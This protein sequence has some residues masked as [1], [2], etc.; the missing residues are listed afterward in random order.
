MSISF[1]FFSS[2]RRHTR[3]KCDWSS[4]VCS[5]DLWGCSRSQGYGCSPFKEV[6]EL[7]LKRRE[8]VWSLSAVGAGYLK[9][10]APSTRGPEWTNLWCTGLHASGIAGK[11]C[12]EDITPE[13]PYATHHPY[14]EIS[15]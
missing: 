7:G 10:A 3:F 14:A 13:P 2:R 6:R 11:L 5:S 12:S 8:T 4:D 15:P 1:F 9:G